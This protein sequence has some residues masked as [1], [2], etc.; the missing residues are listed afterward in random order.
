[1]RLIE[2]F[3]T[4]PVFLLQEGRNFVTQDEI[5]AVKAKWDQGK[6]PLEIANE[7]GVKPLRVTKILSKFYRDRPGKHSATDP[8]TI[9]LVKLDWDSG[10]KPQ[11]IADN[12]GLSNTVV[13]DILRK[14]YPNRSG[15]LVQP[16]RALTDQDK[17]EIVA[18]FRNGSNPTEIAKQYGLTGPSMRELI[19]ARIGEEDYDDEIAA[20]RSMPGKQMPGKI[21][22]E[23]LE[24]IIYL[25][26]QGNY[27]TQIADK[28]NNVVTRVSIA[29]RLRNLPNWE[30]IRTEH[31]KFAKRKSRGPTTKKKDRAGEIGNLQGKGQG[32]KHFHGQHP[33]KQYK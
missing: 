24:K 10:K 31:D 16:T 32:S 7:L 25:Y 15:K 33:S 11:E 6:K 19:I 26:K 23:M 3:E 12:L 1:M 29:D 20:H 9:E 2:L 17:N 30:E 21:T 28:L 27:T 22:P 4:Y 13:T 14:Y 18:A 8:D 5:N